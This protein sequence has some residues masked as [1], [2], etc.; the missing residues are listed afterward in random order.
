MQKHFVTHNATEIL[1]VYYFLLLLLLVLIDTTILFYSLGIC[2]RMM[3]RIL[4]VK[5]LPQILYSKLEIKF[6]R[7]E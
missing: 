4:S 5:I 3:N 7:L 6:L 1:I 2:S